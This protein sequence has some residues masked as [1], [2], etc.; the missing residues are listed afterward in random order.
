ALGEHEVALDP[1]HR[2]EHERGDRRV[3]CGW[4][5]PAERVLEEVAPG[6]QVRLGAVVQRVAL[7]G[8]DVVVA[9]PAQD[10]QEPPGEAA[11]TT[12]ARR[13]R[14][15]RDGDSSRSPIARQRAASAG[16]SARFGSTGASRPVPRG[17]LVGVLASSWYSSS[18]LTSQ[19]SW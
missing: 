5:L 7:V 17:A 9:L 18:T 4:S 10:V 15:V 6:V 1:R 8:Q 16:G 19:M 11:A 3:V 14:K 12:R 13:A 2:G